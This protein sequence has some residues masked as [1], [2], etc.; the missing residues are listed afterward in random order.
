MKTLM[1]IEAYLYA[2]FSSKRQEDGDSLERQTQ[3]AQEW[4]Q[5]ND[6][7]LSEQTFEDLGVSAFK[8]GTKPALSEFISAVKTNKVASGSYLLIEDDDRLS[9]RGWRHTQDLMHDLVGLGIKVVLVKTGRQY[10]SENINDI[11]DNIV[12]MVN[13]DR[14][15]KESERKSH[16]IRAQR[17]R[18]RKN[19]K[20]TGQL[21]AWI[22]RAGNELGF[23]F[24][25]KLDTVKLLVELREKGKSYQSIAKELNSLGLTTGVGSLW[26]AS[27][28]RSIIENRALYGAKAYH[29]TNKATGKMNKDPIDIQSNIFPDVISFKRWTDIQQKKTGGSGRVSRKGAYSKLLRC[30]KCSGALTQRTTTYKGH[31]RL[32]RMCV[33]ATEGKCEQ[34]ERVREPEKYINLVLKDLT[35]QTIENNYTSNTPELEERLKTLETVK[36]NLIQKGLVDMLTDVFVEINNIKAELDRSIENDNNNNEPTET[37]FSKVL[38]IEDVQHRNV[39]LRKLL[40]SITFKLMSKVKTRSKWRVVVKQLNGH[41]V[42][43]I[44]DQKHGFGNTDVY[45]ISDSKKVNNIKPS[46][47][48]EY[49]LN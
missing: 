39:E 43:F 16:L 1:K 7:T 29:D 11:G 21:P 13:A 2:R 25:D 28:V 33:G 45:L 27:G 6:V 8:E 14:A 5:R 36:Q 3:M 46:D 22:K 40:E 30:A 10:N 48:W 19:R 4:C 17:T 42:A 18:A 34:V 38:E 44:L 15:H 35:Y 41:R 47:T 24:N 20:V 9:R 37:S 49:K 31:Q 12:L 26:S 23:E 32:Y